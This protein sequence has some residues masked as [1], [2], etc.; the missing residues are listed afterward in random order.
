MRADGKLVPASLLGAVALAALVSGCGPAKP[1]F[2]RKPYP[3]PRVVAVLPFANH[4]NDLKAPVFM[5]KLAMTAL[6]KGG[7][8]V[9][10]QE[11]MEEKLRSIGITQGG[12][13]RSKTPVE[14]SRALGADALFYGTLKAASH[15]TL[16]VYLKRRVDVETE[17]FDAQGDRLWKHSAS[18]VSSELNLDARK[19]A[20]AMGRQLAEKWVES[21]LSH[22]LYPE[23]RKSLYGVFITL[24]SARS[25]RPV[26]HYIRSWRKSLWHAPKPPRRRRR[27]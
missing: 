4:S 25:S 20:E 1:Q 26:G 9:M 27:R 17:L 10:R 24:P 22:P 18:G 14:I 13:L 5:Q 21:M 11:K 15:L 16:G 19:A 12:Q 7:Y 2:I 8:S 6:G 23:M 3:A